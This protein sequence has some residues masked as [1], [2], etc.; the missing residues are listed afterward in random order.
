M[1]LSKLRGDCRMLHR[2]SDNAIEVLYRSEVLEDQLGVAD[3]GIGGLLL[4]LLEEETNFAGIELRNVGL[5][6]TKMKEEVLRQRKK[7]TDFELFKLSFTEKVR[8]SQRTYDIYREMHHFAPYAEHI[9]LSIFRG[10]FSDAGRALLSLFGVQYETIRDKIVPLMQ[11]EPQFRYPYPGVHNLLHSTYTGKLVSLRWQ[12]K[13]EKLERIETT[14]D[15]EAK[16]YYEEL[17]TT[18][19]RANERASTELRSSSLL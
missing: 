7:C 16:L 3:L 4:G 2:F 8:V 14:N 15:L 19:A 10:D 13:G 12:V 11:A 17:L 6:A 1:L 9:F 5:N 18:L